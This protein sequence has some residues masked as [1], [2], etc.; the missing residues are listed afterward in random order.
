MQN[1]FIMFIT[2]ILCVF[3]FLRIS[4]M[5]RRLLTRTELRMEDLQEYEFVKKHQERRKNGMDSSNTSA[6]GRPEESMISSFKH[7]REMIYERIG[8]NPT[9]RNPQ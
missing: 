9:P 3:R 1:K 8:Y 7:N 4:I 5:A 6:F 2:L